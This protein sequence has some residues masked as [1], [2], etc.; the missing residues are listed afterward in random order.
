MA[1]IP[2]PIPYQG[3]K[4]RLATLILSYAPKGVT[5]LIE[6]FAGSAAITLAAAARNAAREYVIGDSLDP[7]AEL[8]KAII[9]EPE[10]LA[11]E[12]EAVW[13]AQ[14]KKPRD[15][16]L[17]V[18]AEFNANRKPVLLLY[19]MARCVKNAVRFNAY[20]EFNQSADHRRTGMNPQKMR[21]Q[22][23]GASKLLTRRCRVECADYQS[24]LH[25][26]TESD[27]VYM[28]PPYMGVS[29]VRDPRYHQQLDLAKLIQNLE[30][31]N[32]RR[33][34]FLLSFDGSLG[35]KEYGPELPKH[36]N[37]TRVSVH[38]G[39]SSQATLN[40][41]IADT[42]ESVYLSPGLNAGKTVN[43]SLVTPKPI[44]EQLRLMA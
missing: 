14:V 36:L 25:E 24:L 12:Y 13:T 17:K 20:G 37:L 28:D 19:L 31:L 10:A 29:G 6:P 22:I 27:L 30:H 3:S 23:Y 15:H 4:R 39:R 16:Y 26:A 41:E 9:Q 40:G 35:S 7:L 1:S 21:L 44:E 11:D 5:R 8:W 38:T 42:V 32:N 34:P 33:V 2:H 18:R 43:V